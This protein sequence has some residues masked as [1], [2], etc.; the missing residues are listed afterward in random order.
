MGFQSLYIS[1]LH[2]KG[3]QAPCFFLEHGSNQ[4]SLPNTLLHLAEHVLTRNNFSFELS[5]F[6]QIKGIAIGTHMGPSYA[7]K[8]SLFQGTIPQLFLG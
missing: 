1:I 8:Q 7:S 3:R 2:Q 4:P 6:L 5:H